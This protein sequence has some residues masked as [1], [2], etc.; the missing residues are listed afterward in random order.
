MMEYSNN[1]NNH[2]NYGSDKKG[3]N[4]VT[5]D[6]DF[7]DALYKFLPFWPVILASFVLSMTVAYCYLKYAIP[8]Y[9]ISSVILVKD[10]K[11]GTNDVNIL[12]SLDMFGSKKN[13]ENEI[14]IL[15]SR[16]L[17]EQVVDN[18]QLY[19]A[20][21]YKGRMRNISAYQASPVKI[22]IKH[23][24]Y[25]DETAEV[26]F[27][28]DSTGTIKFSTIAARKNEWVVFNGDT[29]RFIPNPAYKKP[30]E[31]AP[32]FF[33]LTNPKR[34]VEDLAGRLAVSA[35]S[36]QSTAIDL[37]F[38]DA[39]PLRG[40]DILNGVVRSYIKAGVQDKNSLAANTLT[41]VEKRLK[42]IVHELDSVESAVQKY[43]TNKGIV[44]IS[45]QGRNFLQ[46]VESNDEKVGQI[47][48]QLA[49]MGEVEKYVS[50]N[51]NNSGI[52]PST[53]GINDPVL[54]QSLQ[55]LHDL[56]IE[57]ERLKKTTA[58]QNP[59]LVSVQDQINKVKPG[60]F[61][62]LKNQRN[63]LVAGRDNLSKTSNT[64]SAAL[65]RIPQN[66]R[67]LLE[68]TRQQV[69]KNNIY[70]FLLQKR[71]ET[72]LSFASAVG[73]SRI[74]DDAKSGID[75][76]IPKPSMIYLIA[77]FFG[78]GFS[79]AFLYVINILNKNIFSKNEI[80]KIIAWPIVG[81]IVQTENKQTVV[82]NNG[83]IAAEQFRHLRTSLDYL[84][85]DKTH[86]KLLITSSI[87]GE[88]KTFIAANLAIS[89]ALT[90]KKVVLVEL[91]LRRPKLNEVFKTHEDVG[92]SNFLTEKF[93]AED[94][95]KST[96]HKN[97]FF[98]DCG[99]MPSNPSELLLTTKLGELLQY[100]EKEFDY[101]IIN[102][103]PVIP[104]TDAYTLSKFCD[105][106]LFVIRY[107][108]TPKNILKRIEESNAIMGLKNVGIIFN[109]LKSS[110]FDKRKYGY[111]YEKGYEKQL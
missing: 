90:N 55:R 105:V 47:N 42:Y 84:G 96:A 106:T 104:V 25:L 24:E 2:I 102:T 7:T 99:L 87:T 95:I 73:D 93:A 108:Y 43:K 14:E 21:F 111:V 34:I 32:L 98:I 49:M 75:P 16:S 66:E 1:N 9:E 72:A 22:E 11:K 3:N 38:K 78:F 53:L 80:K 10:D 69:I 31:E 20:T 85:I 51:E 35:S 88:G 61:E 110:R 17:L 41:F 60:I 52:V 94:I 63:N 74:V 107:N 46:S 83:H 12:E 50:S 76:V 86:K 79:V 67:E 101:V 82:A 91:D 70:T 59:L 37:N 30:L 27:T 33:S 56:E 8:L 28:I 45:E 6:F 39:V 100:L 62:S 65:S 44:D 15:R 13:V 103:A 89:L 5:G 4:Q 64:Y 36:K 58:L 71:E 18:L 92:V 97:L 81:E 77:V 48:M 26:P 109:G 40:E 19:S 68:I 23:P 54:T 57:Y 29:L